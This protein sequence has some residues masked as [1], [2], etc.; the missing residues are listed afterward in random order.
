MRG[1][2][3]LNAGFGN[4]IPSEEVIAIVNPDSSPI[5]R[6]IQKAKEDKTDKAKGITD[7]TQGRKARSVIITDQGKIYMSSLQPETIM[8]RVNVS[9]ADLSEDLMEDE[10]KNKK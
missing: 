9:K 3:L 10:D 2:R 8:G 6:L 5:R 7:F 4:I 1:L